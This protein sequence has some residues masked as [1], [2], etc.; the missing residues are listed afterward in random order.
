MADAPDVRVRL[1]AEGVEQV[2]AAMQKIQAEAR[3]TDGIDALKKGFDELKSSLLDVVSVSAAVAG[4]VELGK[5][6]VENAVHIGALSQETGA[7][8][9]VLSD[10]SVAAK[11]ADVSQETMSSG[12]IKLARNMD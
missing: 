8:V 6:A 7:S 1:S 2:I 3:K 4:M 9:E 10:L 12:L 11:Q 5:T